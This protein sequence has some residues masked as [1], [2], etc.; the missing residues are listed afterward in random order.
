MYLNFSCPEETLVEALAN[1]QAASSAAV[2]LEVHSLNTNTTFV[3]YMF[4]S[5]NI[6]CRKCRENAGNAKT[7]PVVPPDDLVVVCHHKPAV[8][9][10]FRDQSH[11]LKKL[12]QQ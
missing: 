8:F 2:W 10:F 4:H 1:P 7:I 6:P 3:M 11:Y 5:K 12:L 9:V